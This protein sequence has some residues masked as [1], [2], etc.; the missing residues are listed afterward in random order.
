MRHF[1]RVFPPASPVFLRHDL[2][3]RRGGRLER[4][5]FA[6][7]EPGQDAGRRTQLRSDGTEVLQRL[8]AVRKGWGEEWLVGMIFGDI[9]MW[10]IMFIYVHRFSLDMNVAT[11][12]LWGYQMGY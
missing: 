3:R 5:G 4:H 6:A 2:P 1:K 8:G 9:M 7:A 12:Y 11:V 10:M